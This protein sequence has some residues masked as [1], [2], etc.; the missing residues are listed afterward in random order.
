MSLCKPPTRG[1]KCLLSLDCVR[2]LT[3]AGYAVDVSLPD[4]RIAIEV[5]GPT[6]F[7]RTPGPKGRQ[8]GL[9]VVGATAMKRRHLRALGWDVLSVSIQVRY[10]KLCTHARE[11][12]VHRT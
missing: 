1:R 4:L 2:T 3:H 6:H 9:W 8:G 10:D 7:T 12:C 5:D 11:M